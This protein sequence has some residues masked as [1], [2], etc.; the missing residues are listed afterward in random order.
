MNP[1]TAQNIDQF[2]PLPQ[3]LRNN[4]SDHS[5]EVEVNHWTHVKRRNDPERGV[6]KDLQTLLV[7]KYS[8]VGI[9]RYKNLYENRVTFG[10]QGPASAY[11]EDDYYYRDRFPVSRL[12]MLRS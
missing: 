2:T 3:P 12:N 8:L 6:Y 7:D 4:V 10:A 5:V 11:K 9:A 1:F